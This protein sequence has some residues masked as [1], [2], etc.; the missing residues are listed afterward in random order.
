MLQTSSA[1]TGAQDAPVTAAGFSERARVRQESGDLA[2]ALA[3]LEQ[4]AS[5]AQSA[6]E[7]ALYRGMACYL[8]WGNAAAVREFTFAIEHD[9]TCLAAYTWRGAAQLML[10]TNP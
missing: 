9:P 5:L 10:K 6:A 8:N 4:A 3:D 7:G 1:P 2:G